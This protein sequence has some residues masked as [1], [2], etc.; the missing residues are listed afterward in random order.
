MYT[1]VE[2][3]NLKMTDKSANIIDSRWVFKRKLDENGETKYKGR[4]DI[5][6]FKDKNQY[7]LRETYAPVSRISLIR[8]FF[9]IAN[10]Y[11][12]VIRQL[13][14]ETAFLY[15]DLTE[16]IYLEIPEGVQIDKDTRKRFVWK[17]NKSLY[18]LK[19]SP[20]K[21][22]DKFS[23]VM[24]KL[25]F[26]SSD[27]DPCLFI[28]RNKD[29][30]TLVILYVNDILLASPCDKLL[31][32]VSTNLSKEFKIKDLGSPVEFLGV[33]I[34]RDLQN[35]CIKLSQ[36]KFIDKMLFRFGFDRCRPVNTPMKQSDVIN[37]S[38]KERG[39]R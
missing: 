31:T 25:E 1:V 8:S 39:G 12:Y 29:S 7:D 13:D 9:S 3:S 16:D 26:E 34:E 4:L 30:L 18:G 27:V 38:R 14:V 5:R 6:G 23:S 32:E 11:N 22:N 20:K 37:D 35:K 19:I 2:R 15:G 36:T 21:W 10:K 24:S 33:K 28:K 17:L